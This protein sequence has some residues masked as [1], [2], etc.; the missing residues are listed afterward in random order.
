MF[1]E[2]FFVSCPVRYSAAALRTLRLL[3]PQSALDDDA[4]RNV[5]DT[6]QRTTTTVRYQISRILVYL[7]S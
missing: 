5:H 6:R 2:L 7:R 4:F 3:G 1:G